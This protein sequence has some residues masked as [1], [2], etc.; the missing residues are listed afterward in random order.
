MKVR[1]FFESKLKIAY[2]SDKDYGNWI[3]QNIDNAV[4]YHRTLSHR[5][6][7]SRGFEYFE[8]WVCEK[9]RKGKWNSGGHGEDGWNKIGHPQEVKKMVGRH[10]RKSAHDFGHSF[11]DLSRH[12]YERRIKENWK[13][14][15]VFGYKDRITMSL[16]YDFNDPVFVKN[17]EE[18]EWYDAVHNNKKYS[19]KLKVTRAWIENCP[20]LK[21]DYFDK[22]V[23]KESIHKFRTQTG[24][25]G[26][27]TAFIEGLVNNAKILV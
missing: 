25:D 19:K 23:Y 1:D 18:S 15:L 6:S 24:N 22:E 4:K 21:M 26:I 8:W 20:S 12:N 9:L 13:V 5:G 16:S 11:H 14:N 2:M 10:D 3:S 17:L 27:I 7:G